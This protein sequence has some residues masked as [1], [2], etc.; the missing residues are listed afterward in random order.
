[1]C[2]DVSELWD[3]LRLGSSYEMPVL[4]QHGGDAVNDGVGPFVLHSGVG[5]I[6]GEFFS[7]HRSQ[8]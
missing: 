7:A 8:R 1:M 5:Q 2:S 4:P 3:Y 6:A